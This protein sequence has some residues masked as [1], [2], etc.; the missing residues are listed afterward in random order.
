MNTTAKHTPGPWVADTDNWD[1]ID[2]MI[3]CLKEGK[4]TRRE[5][6]AVGKN[7][8]DGYA[9]SLAYCHPKNAALI[10]AAPDLLEALKAAAYFIENVPD[11]APDRQE[12][13]FAV[14]DAW[15][16]ALDKAEGR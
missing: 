12:Q 10:A 15:R 1:L 2:N 6:M 16:V 13:F 9:E 5:W 14:R 4:G 7:D 11:D 3:R 8:N